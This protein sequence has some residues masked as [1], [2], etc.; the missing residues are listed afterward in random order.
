MKL[1][2]LVSFI[3][4]AL[5]GSPRINTSEPICRLSF[6]NKCTNLYFC[7][8]EHI[9]NRSTEYFHAKEMLLIPH[10]S[11][12]AISFILKTRAVTECDL[13]PLPAL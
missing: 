13:L 9:A 1:N 8:L 12:F 10:T 3:R 7:S 6:F 5:N 2:D 11:N 4:F